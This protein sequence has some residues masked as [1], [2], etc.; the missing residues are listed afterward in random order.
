MFDFREGGAGAWIRQGAMMTSEDVE[1]YAAL[2]R[3]KAK[4]KNR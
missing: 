4:R 2:A 3:I 1:W